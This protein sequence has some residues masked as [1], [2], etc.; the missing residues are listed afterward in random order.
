MP[1][2]FSFSSLHLHVRIHP[3]CLRPQKFHARLSKSIRV[4]RTDPHRGEGTGGCSARMG[5]NRAPQLVII[6]L[7]ATRPRQCHWSLT[8]LSLLSQRGCIRRRLEYVLLYRVGESEIAPEF[9][10][11]GKGSGYWQSPARR[12]L[13]DWNVSWV[14]FLHNRNP[15]NEG[16]GFIFPTDGFILPGC[17]RCTSCFFESLFI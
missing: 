2:R 13:E 9:Y 6:F 14:I 15:F 12:R 11:A 8:A 10:G 4:C 16:S 1:H 17:Y 7:L 3:A 5:V